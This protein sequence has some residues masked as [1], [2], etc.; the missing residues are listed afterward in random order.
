ML[1]SYNQ[2]FLL[3]NCSI[4]RCSVAIAVALLLKQNK[5]II[6]II[7]CDS[8]AY[9]DVFKC[10]LCLRICSL[11]SPVSLKGHI[12]KPERVF[13]HGSQR[14]KGGLRNVKFVELFVY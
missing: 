6:S 8:V 2:I 9:F 4:L 13:R 14:V 10:V 7:P 12:G 5:R 3:F 1:P 11:P